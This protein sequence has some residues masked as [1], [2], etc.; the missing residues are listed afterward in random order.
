M[1]NTYNTALTTSKDKIRLLVGDT[2]SADWLLSDEEI[3]F[4]AGQESNVY[5]AAA[6]TA[7]ALA[8]KFARLVDHA[9]G[10]V[11]VNLSQRQ[12]QFAT[13]A[14]DLQTRGGGESAQIV[15]VAP[16]AGGLSISDVETNNADTDRVPPLFYR[17]QFDA[18][19]QST[20]LND[21]NNRTA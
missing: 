18:A 1:A 10:D 14:K 20:L 5:L 11:R 16:Y 4:F 19:P 17:G 9:I 8:A 21:L 15:G 3:N 12:A 13:L 7:K 2:D 6:M